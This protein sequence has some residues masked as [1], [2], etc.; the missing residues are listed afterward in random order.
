MERL[1]TYLSNAI[2]SKKNDIKMLSI[3]QQVK[4]IDTN[5]DSLTTALKEYQATPVAEEP[6]PTKK[7]KAK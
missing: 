1:E 5:L 3:E 2:K 4:A 7:K 6:L